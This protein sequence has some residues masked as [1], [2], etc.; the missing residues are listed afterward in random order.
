[1]GMTE[2]FVV[3]VG[4]RK[5]MVALEDGGEGTVR[6]TVDGRER[7]MDARRVGGGSWSLIEGGMARLIDVDGVL[8]RLSVQVSH[9]DGEP[10]QAVVEVVPAASGTTA[11]ADPVAM[12]GPISVRA[13]IPGKVV[14]VLVK[15]GDPV[16]AGQ[17]LLVL[18]A[19]KMENELRA[20]RAAVVVALHAVEGAAVEAGQELVSLG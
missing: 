8:P 6:I 9:E 20:P 2:T 7:I 13:P 1:M 10:R 19:M 18:E 5:H 15:A 14:K 11:T 17:T 12:S 4:E 16:K 3:T